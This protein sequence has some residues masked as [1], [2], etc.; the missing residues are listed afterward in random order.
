MGA[1]EMPTVSEIRTSGGYLSGRIGERSFSATL[2][3]NPAGFAIV[4]GSQ[5]VPAAGNSLKWGDILLLTPSQGPATVRLIEGWDNTP[6]FTIMSPRDPASGQPSGIVITGR[7]ISDVSSL[8]ML[9]G[10]GDLIQA[11]R[12]AD[13]VV[14]QVT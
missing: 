11:I 7:S 8:V 3:R 1:R 2:R 4:P 12:G 10:L 5:P 14:V 6:L 9:D 13:D